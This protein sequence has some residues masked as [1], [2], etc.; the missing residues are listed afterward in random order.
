[1]GDACDVIARDLSP[2]W[3]WPQPPQPED[4]AW[5][6]EVARLPA[7]TWVLRA[8]EGVPARADE[9]PILVRDLDG[10]RTG[11]Y[12]G[13]IRHRGRTLQIEPRL[14]VGV[15]TGWIGVAHNVRIIDNTAGTT[16]D[17]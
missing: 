14:G 15:I 7:Q 6:S 16:S 8:D 10:W 17:A 9:E 12:I 11:R 5:L 2:Q 13:E 1:M 3:A 4:D